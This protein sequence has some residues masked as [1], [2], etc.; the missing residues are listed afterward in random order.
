MW[1]KNF[2]VVALIRTTVVYFSTWYLYQVT[3][4]Y[5]EKSNTTENEAL[6]VCTHTQNQACSFYI[7]I[8]NRYIG[9][10]IFNFNQMLT[11]RVINVTFEE[12][13]RMPNLLTT[14]LIVIHQGRERHQ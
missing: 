5:E 7:E 10:Y 8:L 6:L 3:R 1:T 11:K 4:H 13:C 12:K 2:R 9:S 14:Y